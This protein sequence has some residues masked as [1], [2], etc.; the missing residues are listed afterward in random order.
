MS[1]QRWPDTPE[2]MAAMTA[3]LQYTD[4]EVDLP[5]VPGPEGIMVSRSFKLPPEL[6]QRIKEAAS[7]RGTSYSKLLR[8]F[9]EI[10]LAA[11]EIDHPI[12]LADALKALASL[13]KPA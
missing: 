6:D 1:D 12:S 2:E 13:P 5:P 8:Q 7:A 9:A 10:G 11:E 3:R 4:D